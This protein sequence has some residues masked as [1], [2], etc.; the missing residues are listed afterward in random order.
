MKLYIVYGVFAAFL[1]TAALAAKPEPM[2]VDQV[3]AAVAAA[4]YTNVTGC[5]QKHTGKGAW[6]CTA[7]PSTGGNPVPVTVTPHGKVHQGDV[8]V[9]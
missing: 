9:D 8:D 3:T 1:S 4:G 6:H 2:T 5:A 7:V